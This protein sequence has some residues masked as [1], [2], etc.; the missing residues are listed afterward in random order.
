MTAR[1]QYWRRAP[2]GP[3]QSADGTKPL[4]SPLHVPRYPGYLLARS[5]LGIQV[6]CAT[7]PMVIPAPALPCH[8]FGASVCTCTPRQA[9]IPRNATVIASRL[10]CDWF[11][12]PV[13]I[14]VSSRRLGGSWSRC[15][16]GNDR[17]QKTC[18]EDRGYS[19]SRGNLKNA[20]LGIV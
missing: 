15:H 14:S 8:R 12:N 19:V 11:V 17:A 20:H 18:R 6:A 2:H 3:A 16:P 7:E 10:S 9:S 13:A 4:N 5:T 1:G